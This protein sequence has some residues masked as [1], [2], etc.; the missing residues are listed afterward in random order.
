MSK[1]PESIRRGDEIQS[2]GNGLLKRFARP[3]SLSAQYGF[4]L[5]ERFLNRREIRRI[6]WQKQQTTAASF[7]GRSDTRRKVDREVIQDHDLPWV[8]AGCQDLFDV[9]L[10]S[11]AISRSIQHKRWPH[12]SKRQRGEKPHDGAIIAWHFADGALSSWGIRIQRGH[13]DVGT[14]LVDKDQI[15]TRQVSGLG[16]PGGAFGFFLLACSQGLFFRVQPRACLAR[17]MLAG[18]TLMPCEASH[19]WQC[20]SRLASGWALN[21]CNNPAC[22]AAPLTFGRPGMALGKT[23]PLSRRADVDTA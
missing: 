22:K 11:G 1:P 4:Q 20:C 21:C 18:L 23:W 12:A 17:V 6:G 19:I 7:N 3:G 8:Q 16:A 10:K 15:L 13:G 2:G 5:G 14:G 9:D